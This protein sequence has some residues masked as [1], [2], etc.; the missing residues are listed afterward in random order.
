MFSV[1]TFLITFIIEMFVVLDLLYFL[2]WSYL[3]LIPSHMLSSTWSG[4]EMAA[5]YR[6]LLV[7]KRLQMYEYDI[8][9]VRGFGVY[10]RT[11]VSCA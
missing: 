5:S 9:D 6:L 1:C 8:Q 4:V 11:I 10:V 2:R 7:T 3:R